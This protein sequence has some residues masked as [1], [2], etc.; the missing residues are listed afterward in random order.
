MAYRAIRNR[1]FDEHRD[2]MIRSYVLAWTFVFCRFWTRAAPTGLQGDESDMIWLTW[3]A[4]ILDRRNS[5]AIGIAAWRRA[6]RP[7]ARLILPSAPPP[8]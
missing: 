6:G 7:M 1:V 8:L 3:V 2:W 5:T 4:P